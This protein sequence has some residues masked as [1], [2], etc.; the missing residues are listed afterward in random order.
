MVNVCIVIQFQGNV[1]V[2]TTSPNLN[3]NSGSACKSV[4]REGGQ[5]LQNECKEKYPND[6]KFGEIA[7]INGCGTLECNKVYLTTLPNW[8]SNHNPEQV[9]YFYHIVYLLFSFRQVVKMITDLT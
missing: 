8:N 3:L 9:G 5:Q 2:V 4:L 7:V 1:I 6:I